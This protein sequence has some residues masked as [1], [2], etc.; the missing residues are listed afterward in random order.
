MTRLRVDPADAAFLES[1][2]ARLPGGEELNSPVT[3][4]LN[5]KI[6]VR[7]DAPDQ[8]Q[9]VTELVLNRSNYTGSPVCVATNRLF[10]DRA[11][12]LG[13]T[14][15]GFTGVESP[16]VCRD[17]V[18]VYAVQPLSGGSTPGPDAK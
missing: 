5:G 2:L 10:L 6:A 4:D 15:I 16:F 8:P 1:S 3:L 18:R 17:Q 14:E 7:A 12:R 13:F 9:Q 11:L